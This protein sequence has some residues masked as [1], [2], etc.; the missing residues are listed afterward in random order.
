MLRR[1][2]LPSEALPEGERGVWRAVSRLTDPLSAYNIC[3]AQRLQQGGGRRLMLTERGVAE[4]L[5]RGTLKVCVSCACACVYSRGSGR[6]HSPHGTP[7]PQAAQECPTDA[8]L[9]V[10]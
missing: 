2:E 3:Q 6:V 7:E 9:V 4:G 1:G 5:A 10:D 8:R